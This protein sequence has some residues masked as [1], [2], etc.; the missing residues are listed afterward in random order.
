M[1]I[2]LFLLIL[3]FQ[4]VVAMAAP[5]A[6]PL[7]E[8][9][10]LQGEPVKRFALGKFY[11]VEFWATW[12]GPCVD[13]MPHLSELQKAY[14]PKGVTIIGVAGREQAATLEERQQLVEKFLREHKPRPTY[15]IAF[16]PD[17]QIYKAYSGIHE[18]KGIPTAFVVNELGEIA[19][20]G[21]PMALE[22]VLPKILNGTFDQGVYEKEMELEQ[23]REIKL[24]E[25]LVV[26]SERGDYP[27]AH[28]IVDELSSHSA[29]NASNLKFIRVK[30]LISEGRTQ[31]AC[32]LFETI[33][34]GGD[35][36]A[37]MSVVPA[38]QGWQKLQTTSKTAAPQGE[39]KITF[40]KMKE[41]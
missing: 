6:I 5:K 28:Q 25:E 14:G 16:D 37:L 39:S 34:K 23:E 38:L 1:Q 2:F 20:T 9:I 22:G 29:F 36:I 27:R 30:I 32:R 12:C 15:A 4:A 7:D 3:A 10:W 13:S 26:S 35:D 21:H 11:V 18:I 8:A 31:E 24:Y 17:G 33:V 19:F 40:V 41:R